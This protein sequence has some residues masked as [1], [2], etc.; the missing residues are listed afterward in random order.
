MLMT[1]I[2]ASVSPGTRANL[3]TIYDDLK[4]V[5][6]VYG[7]LVCKGLMNKAVVGNKQT[8]RYLQD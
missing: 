6:M 5:G 2:L 7:E 8:T 4:I 3:H 1:C